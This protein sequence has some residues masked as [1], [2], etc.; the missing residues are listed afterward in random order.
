ME[1][2]LRCIRGNRFGKR[3]FDIDS[4]TTYIYIYLISV[5]NISTNYTSMILVRKSHDE[6]DRF[7]YGNFFRDPAQSFRL[8]SLMPSKR[9]HLDDIMT[10]TH[11]VRKFCETKRRV[12]LW[13]NLFLSPLNSLDNNANSGF[14]LRLRFGFLCTKNCLH[15]WEEVELFPPF[16]Y[17]HIEVREYFGISEIHGRYFR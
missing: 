1:H 10:K 9:L 16:R 4:C 13:E 5:E 8:F 12:Y 6:F 2:V 3:L 7:M 14:T 11:P 17:G 15:A